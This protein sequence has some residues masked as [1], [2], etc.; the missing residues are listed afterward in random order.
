MTF[1]RDYNAVVDYQYERTI[2][3]PQKIDVAGIEVLFYENSDDGNIH[4]AWL[5]DSANYN[6]F[7]AVSR[8]EV[9]RIIESMNGTDE[10]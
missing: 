9:M 2:D 7:G 8:E 3:E 6:L 10:S 4:A 1:N 5:K